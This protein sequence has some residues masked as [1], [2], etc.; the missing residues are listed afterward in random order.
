[1]D[2][3]LI[4][5]PGDR[6]AGLPTDLEH[7]PDRALTKLL[8]VLPSGL[9]SCRDSPFRQQ[10]MLTSGPPRKSGW[11]TALIVHTR[12]DGGRDAAVRGV[13]TWFG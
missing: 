2:V 8:G 1:M 11:F 10:M 6:A 5:H 7:D 9:A 3:E 4:C 13:G 12:A